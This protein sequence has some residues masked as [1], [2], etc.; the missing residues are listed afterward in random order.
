[1]FTAM[2]WV[3]AV[4]QVLPLAWELLHATGAAKKKKGK[5]KACDGLVSQSKAKNKIEKKNQGIPLV[6]QQK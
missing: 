2:A 5:K 3:T 1:M 6:V 4:E